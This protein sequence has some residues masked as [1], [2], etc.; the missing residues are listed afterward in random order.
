MGV[1]G[2]DD[3]FAAFDIESVCDRVQVWLDVFGGSGG[4]FPFVGG[5][6]GAWT[7]VAGVDDGWFAG[8]RAAAVYMDAL[9]EWMADAGD[10]VVGEDAFLFVEDAVGDAFG[11]CRAVDTEGVFLADRLVPAAEQ[12]AGV[13]D[14]V[15]EMVM[16]EE[17]VV[18]L[19]RPE[20]G[21]DEFVGCGRS[22]VEHDLFAVDVGDEGGSEAGGGWR[23]GAGA[24]DVE[25]GVCSG[26]GGSL[27][28]SQSRI[29]ALR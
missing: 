14:V 25:G 1:A 27:V 23:G 28:V 6:D 15:V 17:E 7:D 11:E 10:P 2:E 3:R 26:H 19:G 29:L 13:V 5:F 12:E 16:S 4:H 20:A 24:E 22:A 21:L 8:Q 9:A 18:D